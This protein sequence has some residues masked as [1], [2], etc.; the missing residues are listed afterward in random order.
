MYQGY[1]A[2]RGHKI[3]CPKG[4]YEVSYYI[5]NH[6]DILI[7]IILHIIFNIRLWLL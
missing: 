3:D 2:K 4:A 5:I 1:T 6:R 7:V